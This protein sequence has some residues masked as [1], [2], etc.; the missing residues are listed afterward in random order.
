MLS[1]VGTALVTTEKWSH[2]LAHIQR[3][4]ADILVCD[5][6]WLASDAA[7]AKARESSIPVSDWERA[8]RRYFRLVRTI[9]ELV[10]F[11]SSSLRSLDLP[12]EQTKF[13]L[14]KVYI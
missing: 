5:V 10:D 2:V 8:V 1:A 11:S 4:G 3:E 9:H 12:A 6:I 7:F 13:V 14:A